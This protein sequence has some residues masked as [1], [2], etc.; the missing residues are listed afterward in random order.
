MALIW[1]NSCS[2][3]I[4]G[5]VI[6]AVLLLLSSS[7][8]AADSKPQSK[9]LEAWWEKLAFGAAAVGKTSDQSTAPAED[10]IPYDWLKQQASQQIVKPLQDTF[11]G[12]TAHPGSQFEHYYYNKSDQLRQADRNTTGYSLQ[13]HRRNTYSDIANAPNSNVP[14]GGSDV[15]PAG[16]YKPIT[17]PRQASF[18]EIATP[19]LKQHFDAGAHTGKL[20]ILRT[21]SDIQHLI[22]C[23]RAGKSAR[24][25]AKTYA[26]N[27]A[28]SKAI[29]EA[30]S[31][32]GSNA[33][34]YLANNPRAGQALAGGA[35]TFA[36]LAY[37]D[38]KAIENIQKLIKVRSEKWSDD[39]RNQLQAELN[40]LTDQGSWSGNLAGL[41]LRMDAFKHQFDQQMSA[42]GRQL[43]EAWRQ[44]DTCIGPTREMKRDLDRELNR[45]P[46]ADTNIQRIQQAC[47][48]AVD[49]ELEVK[50]GG[51]QSRLAK[52]IGVYV[53]TAEQ[54]AGLADTC[55]TDEQA[56]RIIRLHASLVQM[57]KDVG[58]DNRD[59]AQLA[60]QKAKT[61]AEAGKAERGRIEQELAEAGRVKE[62]HGIFKSAYDSC[63]ESAALARS[64][65]ENYQ[66][67]GAAHR[68]R[69]RNF[70]LFLESRARDML[71]EGD[72]Q[73]A[74]E[75]IAVLDR[76]IKDYQPDRLPFDTVGEYKAEIQDAAADLKYMAGIEKKIVEKL[77]KCL[78]DLRAADAAC[79]DEEGESA[80][81]VLLREY[82]THKQNTAKLPLL[83]KSCTEITVPSLKGMTERQ[84]LK[85]LHS[86]D[87]TE[88]IL[89]HDQVT[90]EPGQAGRVARQFPPNGKTLPRKG[91]VEIYLWKPYSQADLCSDLRN[92]FNGA[93]HDRNLKQARTLLAKLESLNCSNLSGARADLSVAEGLNRRAEKV[94]VPEVVGRPLDRALELL[95]EAGFETDPIFSV[96]RVKTARPELDNRVKTQDPPGKGYQPVGA[97]VKLE[98]WDFDPQ[99]AAAATDCSRL[100]GSIAVWDANAGQ[101]RCVCPRGRVEITS[102]KRG[103]FCADCDLLKSYFDREIARGHET[104]ARKILDKVAG[105][106]IWHSEGM[107]RVAGLAHGAAAEKDCQKQRSG[108]F[109]VFDN[110]GGYTCQCPQGTVEAK[111]RSRGLTCLDCDTM[112]G[113]FSAALEKQDDARAQKILERSRVCPWFD[114]GWRVLNE[115]NNRPSPREEAAAWCR[116]NM[117][118][119]VPVFVS[120]VKYR[121]DCGEKIAMNTTSGSVCRSCAEVA[122][123]VN[124][125]GARNDLAA[126]RRL[127]QISRKCPWHD[128]VA[129]RLEQAEQTQRAAQQAPALNQPQHQNP[130]SGTW[131]FATSG[132]K[133]IKYEGHNLDG[134]SFSHDITPGDI[135]CTLHLGQSGERINGQ[136]VCPDNVRVQV[137]G[138]VNDNAVSICTLTEDGRECMPGRIDYQ[139]MAM[140][141]KFVKG[142]ATWS[143]V[144][145]R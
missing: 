138:S 43:F 100:E 120:D 142:N 7:I 73:Q 122:D 82:Q 69:W 25:C 108:S 45:L 85:E 35:V 125:A 101:A 37:A 132:I 39:Q 26:L 145:Q 144:K 99:K 79:P 64:A 21:V 10:L 15:A 32:V 141:G 2:P 140:H 60:R 134:S 58:A 44:M 135:R 54:A 109:P 65:Y 129:H 126:I 18:T 137:D 27:F 63:L 50:I 77:T 88:R 113:F 61:K 67:L 123:M 13:R 102:K 106:C 5:I 23:Q 33:G 92:D 91:K 114:E 24:E 42:A 22:D 51:V 29:T 38:I 76:Y 115:F 8:S 47:R 56:E 19:I 31:I 12:K 119:S 46:S 36:Y 66:E 1:R 139:R 143:A 28:N 72:A 14:I 40:E 80:R 52:T 62:A 70:T 17:P 41:R 95:A 111:T 59:L 78:T 75:M 57:E 81:Q 127:L 107:D 94:R 112:M 110:S 83:A 9:S 53:E 105:H 133:P 96:K 98:C 117:P 104:R 74:A 16:N 136:M 55:T 20:K 6:S 121:C 131:S 116:E 118:G 48:D 124:A 89:T 11:D 128:Q 84:A 30:L 87:L 49:A 4:I 130:L 71:T 97:T 68:A 103:T 3:R 90:R 86:L 34:Y 93:I